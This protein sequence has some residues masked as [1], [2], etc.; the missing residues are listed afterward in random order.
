MH[1][2][3]FK[4]GGIPLHM[5]GLC[6]AI[7]FLLAWRA[8]VYL[9]K[10]TNQPYEDVAAL[11][12]WVMICSVLGARTAYVIEHWSAEFAHN[13]LAILRIDQGGLMFYGG[14][15]GAL[16]L[17]VGYTLYH[18]L[19][20]FD[21]GDVSAAVV[22]LGQFFGRL[23]CFMHGCCYGNR[24]DAWFGVCFPKGSPAWHEQVSSGLIPH[25][26]LKA[27]AVIPT[28]LIESCATLILFVVLFVL[29][30]RH[31]KERGFVG[32]CYLMGYAMLRFF[33]E[34]VRGD[35]RAVV[36][37]FSIGQTISI[38]IFLCGVACM[39]WA[40]TKGR[41]SMVIQVLDT[42]KN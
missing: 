18:R 9:R 1:S 42:S 13:P 12:T 41:S 19:N 35:P 5:Y 10:R 23:G 6:M 38:L 7:G 8:I 14:L 32:G 26:A 4:I 15:I 29:Y 34:Y 28:Q 16:M 22:P 21:A 39:V 2:E 3:L 25:T 11:L 24:T 17:Y 20:F 40:K 36:G 27:L 31:Y 30:P 33:I 37:P